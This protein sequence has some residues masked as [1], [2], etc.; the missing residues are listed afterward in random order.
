MSSRRGLPCP[1]AQSGGSSTATDTRTPTRAQVLRNIPGA[2]SPADAD[3]LFFVD[4][5]TEW[6]GGTLARVAGRQP[7]IIAT[8]LD[9][10]RVWAREI[11]DG[12]IKDVAVDM[13][14][15]LL[16]VLSNSYGS[17]DPLPERVERIDG[18][19]GEISWQY[20]TDDGQLSEVAVRRDG[21]VFFVD[22]EY[23]KPYTYLV[24]VDGQTGL[25]A[26]TE[27]PHGHVTRTVNG[28]QDVDV[29]DWAKAT[30][31]VILA[32]GTTTVV[33]SRA[34]SESHLISKWNGSYWDVYPDS[35]SPGSEETHV[36]LVSVASDSLTPSAL[37][38]TVDASIPTGLDLSA[39]RI[40]PRPN[41]GFVVG[42][43]SAPLVARID[44]GVL[45]AITS[46]GPTGVYSSIWE[47]EYAVAATNAYALVRGYSSGAQRADLVTFDPATEAPTGQQQLLS[48]DAR[49]RFI[50]A[51]D[52]VHVSGSTYGAYDANDTEVTNGLWASFGN[53]PAV[54][55]GVVADVSLASGY[56]E[57]G[58]LS[59]NGP[60]H[61][62]ATYFMP[63]TVLD[64]TNGSYLAYEYKDQVIE[65]FEGGL[66]DTLP[67][68]ILVD[69]DATLDRFRTALEH[70]DI[71][72]FLGHSVV[73][74]Q[75]CEAVPTCESVG[76]NF[77]DKDLVKAGYPSSRPS[78]QTESV[79]EPV[80]VRARLFLVGACAVGD[81][82]NSMWSIG[83]ASVG[84][85]LVYPTV[86]GTHLR[87][88]ASAVRQLVN[89][90][91]GQN[92]MTVAQAIDDV[93]ST[94]LQN[95]ELKFAFR[96]DGSV[97]FR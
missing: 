70:E 78:E 33:S 49:L 86:K 8:S 67:P 77:A 27:L 40:I 94:V 83:D 88:A 18:V 59:A 66:A 71:V 84:Q 37:E 61:P 15:G 47:V 73:T 63:A 85:V 60:S 95:V 56:L 23:H 1:R 96:G 6:S 82:F 30:A 24:A 51:D 10:A 20:F 14:G 55:D 90:L 80:T 43:R 7:R 69:Q 81:V 76:L 79:Q 75:D 11:S 22:E 41:G 17:S 93:N 97:R 21:A 12:T 9:G 29:N 74:S 62:S 46:I 72:V 34:N 50:Q 92:R 48:P 89:D 31:P 25:P 58:L 32:D 64:D 36:D 68:H 53:A 3:R 4:E 45:S 38:L 16:L 44:A 54:L 5:A 19:T 35:S 28:I 91:T 42:G 57:A 87:W 26:K 52:G 39:W 13:N 65:D 2:T